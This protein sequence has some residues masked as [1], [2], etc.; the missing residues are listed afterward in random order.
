MSAPHIPALLILTV[1]IPGSGKTTWAKKYHSHHGAA[2][3]ISNDEVRLEVT[4][5]A[6][7]AH[8]ETENHKDI[9][10]AARVKVEQA[11]ADK[12]LVVIVD[13]TNVDLDEWEAYNKLAKKYNAIL[14][15]KL[16][17]VP[18]PIAIHRI[19]ERQ[20]RM[21]PYPVLKRKWNTLLTN[22][23]QITNYF[24]WVDDNEFLE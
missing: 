13:G 6:D 17:N 3:I 4:G 14:I 1:G 12:K 2:V 11:L 7:S 16:F 22:L 19:I 8:V 15:A 18:P 5:Y 9:Y 20:D 23:P 10:S 21:V 24:S